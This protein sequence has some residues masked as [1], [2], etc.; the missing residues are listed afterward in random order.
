MRAIHLPE[1]KF[2]K[3]FVLF[4]GLALGMYV[5]PF[6]LGG[7]LLYFVYKNLDNLIIRNSILVAI[8]LPTLLFGS[9]WVAGITQGITS[10]TPAT[11]STPA[12]TILPSSTPVLTITPTTTVV[13]T[14]TP[15]T[16]VILSPTPAVQ[17]VKKSIPTP[18]YH[19]VIP[20]KAKLTP[21]PIP[22]Y[23]PPASTSSN[24]SVPITNN[25]SS[26]F[27]CNCAK[28]CPNMIS[29]A[30]A[31]FQLNSCGCSARDSDHDGVAC[32]AQCQ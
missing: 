16:K 4:W 24:N 23:D 17:S 10:P 13:P 19:I 20:D 28:T 21:T 11:V 22:I 12:P 8:V 3:I 27:T 32:D 2:L 29:C 30:E 1:N 15:S 6:I 14:A 25:Q 9:I 5:L 7:F 31:Q 18:T 26:G